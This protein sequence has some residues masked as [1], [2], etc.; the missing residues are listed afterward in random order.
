MPSLSTP[1][2]PKRQFCLNVTLYVHCL[3][4]LYS[5]TC[6]KRTLY[7]MEFVLNGNIFMSRQ[8][9][10]EADV[11]YPGLNGNYLTRKRKSKQA[12]IR[13]ISSLP[14]CIVWKN[15][16]H[17]IHSTEFC[18]S[19]ALIF[20][21]RIWNMRSGLFS[22]SYLVLWLPCL[23]LVYT[24]PVDG[25]GKWTSKLLRVN[26]FLI[27]ISTLPSFRPNDLSITFWI[28]LLTVTALPALK[29]N[30]TVCSFRKFY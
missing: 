25:Q 10:A 14:E 8:F 22:F 24:R 12:F 4:C 28:Q 23:R 9:G 17:P 20:F 1:K 27:V 19:N 13:K 29:F 26:C 7:W 2:F 16:R 6:L 15:F 3:S 11:K 5:K 18:F 30:W 21:N